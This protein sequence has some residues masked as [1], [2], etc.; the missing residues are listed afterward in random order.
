[1][2]GEPRR[3]KPVKEGMPLSHKN[4]RMTTVA[5]IEDE[6]HY[7]HGV[8]RL[9]NE[10]GRFTVLHAFDNAE[11]AL[12][13]LPKQP[14]QVALVDIN[15]PGQPGPSA[16]LKLR[17]SCPGLRCVMFTIFADA[18]NLFASLQAGAAGYLLKTS[19]PEEILAGLDEL[20]AGGAPMSRP[21]A[22][23]VLAAFARPAPRGAENVNVTPREAEIMNALA[24]GLAYKEIA[25]ELG[26]SAATVKN[27]LYRIY[28]KLHVRSRT[29]AV[30]KWLAR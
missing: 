3:V 24:R 1:M 9:L 5:L 4:L 6:P 22:R 11:E 27:H 12:R 26:I 15:L 7:R 19:T 20:V 10:S 23:R 21:I 13:V 14:P 2:T 25:A 16:V 18:E 8:E 28:E 30:V 17:E 29:E